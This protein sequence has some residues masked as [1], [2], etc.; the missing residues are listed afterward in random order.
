MNYLDFLPKMDIVDKNGQEIPF[1]PNS[2]QKSFLEKM[3]NKN[4]I[5]KAR[6]IGFTSLILAIFTTDFL[7]VPNSRSVCI[8]HDASSAQ[9]LLDKVKFYLRS[10]EKK[11]LGIN[12]KY[13]S[14]SELVNQDTNSTFFIGPA[15]SK[16]FGR[17]ETLNNLHLSEFG[18]YP[19]P[20][21]LL[22]SVMQ[23]VVPNGRVIVESTANGM[24]FFKTFW[25]RAKS[26]SNSFT[27]HF[28]DNRFYSP[29]FL[30]EKQ[31]ELGDMFPQEYPASDLEAFLSS[32][33]PFFDKASLA[34][35]LTQIKDPVNSFK[36]YHDLPV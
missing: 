18:F 35:Y 26:G 17:G 20:E 34:Y 32:G 22:A 16:T 28:H 7:T 29:E 21:A 5:L 15:G 24:N 2:E 3:T 25:D 33:N 14:R 12:L 8:S 27:A 11:G 6:Q 10:M 31:L 4:V 19:D 1:H 13:N 9:K 36:D 23:A 30:A